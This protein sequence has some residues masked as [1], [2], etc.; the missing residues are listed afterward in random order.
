MGVFQDAPELGYP[1]G[2]SEERRAGDRHV[3]WVPVR[4]R[5]GE[6]VTLLAVSRN[7]S[8]C[9]V[10]VIVGASL[11]VG[12]RVEL[13]P[14]VPDA[15]ERTVGGE[16]VRVGPNREDA[17]GLWR[18]ETAIAF[19]ESLGELEGAFERLEEQTPRPPG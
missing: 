7:I 12:Q 8:V 6:D 4:M 18:Y 5:A 17:E 19:E 16:I 2:M 15:D 1:G 13:T 3:L 14:Q 9:G 10:L 11:E